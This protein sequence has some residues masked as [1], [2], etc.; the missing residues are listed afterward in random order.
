MERVELATGAS[1]TIE[2]QFADM[3]ACC[4]RS[5]IGKRLLGAFYIHISAL[6]SLDSTLQT[7]EQLARRYLQEPIAP[8]L[9]KFSTAQ[10]KISY[11]LYPDC[12][13]DPHPALEQSIQ[14]DLSTGLVSSRDYRDTDNPPVLHRKENF[15]APSHP[16]YSEFAA[17]T[18][19]QDRLGLLNNSRELGTRFG[20][21]QRLAA[22][23]VELHGHRL[24][25]PLRASS[26][27]T[28]PK[29]DRH[30]AALV[31]TG[32]R[33]ACPLRASSN[34]TP[35]KIDRHKAALVRTA[36]SK[37]MRSALEA[38][39]FTTGTTFFDYGCGHGGDVQRMA[40]QGFDGSGWD[41]HYQPDT[42]RVAADVVNL[43]YVIN[44][45]EDPVERRE[46]LVNAWA[47][48]QRVLIVSAQVLIED[49]IR[50]TVIYGDGVITRRNTFQKNYEQ[51][52][53]KV[54]IDQVL[55]VD[56]IP[57]ALGIYFV[58]RDEMQAQSFRASRFRSR[59]TT[60][61]VK[62]SVQRFEAYKE[63]LAP[64]M[65]FVSDR[66]RLPTAEETQAFASLQTE[67]GT[68]RRAFQV[69]LQATNAQ[70][71]DAIADKRRQDL[72]GYLALSHFS[73]RPK[74]QEFSSVVQNDIKALF[75]GYQQACTAAD[76]MLLSIGKL[77]IM[78]ARCHASAVGKKLPHS[79][80][81]HVSVIEALDPLLRL[82]EG[83]ASRTNMLRMASNGRPEEANVIK[84]HCGKP[85][86]S[87]LVYPEFDADPHPALYTSMQVDLRDLHVSD[88]DYDPEDNP[89]VLH[90]KDLLV[91]S[92]YPLY[93]KFAKLNRQEKDW[94]LLE[95]WQQIS[96][97][98]GWQKCLEDH[99]A[100]LKGHRV[101]WQKD[102]D[103]YQIKLIRSARPRKT[104]E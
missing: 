52:E 87:Y 40:E 11:L 24:A 92:D 102:A 85:K 36:L 103:P 25:C 66:G 34:R 59:T 22:H 12:E 32:H 35:P 33:L 51:E 30:K 60:P 45:I 90:Q 5:S 81:V 3:V 53:L 101:V 7:Y 37:P 98:R 69:V 44:V 64:L 14:V 56:A 43:G 48:T 2:Q 41:P 54:Y 96:E 104:V 80:W 100:E 68:L 21:Q 31:R 19:Q 93:E 84:F 9:I 73:R 67:F 50:G 29:I 57:V 86:I 78:G 49:R 26:N 79:L 65:V 95:D 16:H 70:E 13:I 62:A 47:L 82:Y 61:R 42:P 38:G 8:T 99:C 94:G 23:H 17:L 20:W 18:R 89:P 1:K 88:R 83:C 28:P 10:P 75:G 4:D 27:R 91:L 39:L 72:L 6:P 74:L 76:L 46:A 15:I 97:R 63:L 77:E 58:F 71:W 55:A